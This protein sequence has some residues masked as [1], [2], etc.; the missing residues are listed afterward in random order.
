[1]VLWLIATTLAVPAFADD[2]FR[3]FIEMLRPE[4]RALGVSR[5][6]FDAATQGLEPDFSLPDLVIPGRPPKPDTQQPEFIKSPAEYLSEASL[7]RLAAQARKLAVEH[8]A[9][10]AA[11][12]Q[13]FGVPSTVLLAIWG[14]ET[15]FGAY[16][17][18]NNAFRV[19][20]TQAY[21]G[22]RKE[23]FRQEFLLALKIVADGHA[24]IADMRSSWAGAMGLTQFLPS[25]FYKYAVD[26]DGDG[27]RDIW[28]SV[29]DALAS[30]AKQLVEKG[31]QAG[32]GWAYEV[33]VP[34]DV[35]CTRA[36]P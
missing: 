28:S 18:P 2:A 15:D 4:A 31:W 34:R 35:D 25:E 17:L 27:R 14:R 26:F 21:V 16:R 7:N 32:K 23:Q 33:R 19:L 5:A 20:G 24:G 22:R 10:L 11:I 36:D 13:K 12:E 8:R 6:I 3:S 29:P 9:T 1:M 30:A